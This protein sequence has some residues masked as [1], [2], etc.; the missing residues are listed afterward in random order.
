MTVIYPTIRW[1]AQAY[2]GLAQIRSL[3]ACQGGDFFKPTAN[4]VTSDAKNA[5]Q[6]AQRQAFL[7]RQ[8]FL[9]GAQNLIALLIP[10]GNGLGIIPTAALAGFIRVGLFGVSIQ[11][12]AKQI[13][14]TALTAFH[15][16]CNQKGR[17]YRFSPF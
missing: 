13:F 11:L 17:D 9:I 14:T 3:Q 1:L 2:Q 8:A 6:P 15:G 7:K 5:S 4:R 10:I 16:D 12:V